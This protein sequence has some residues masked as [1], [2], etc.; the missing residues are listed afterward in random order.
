MHRQ[1]IQDG[2]DPLHLGRNP[3]FHLVE[4]V[5]PVDGRASIIGHSQ[6]LSC[7]WLKGYIFGAFGSTSIID[8]LVGSFGWSAGPVEHERP[9]CPEN[10]WPLLVI[11]MRLEKVDEKILQKG[12]QQSIPLF[13]QKEMISIKET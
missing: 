1:I 2:V 6:H 4:K 9:V 8:L 12:R 10:F 13:M 3:L 5:D 7:G 11:L